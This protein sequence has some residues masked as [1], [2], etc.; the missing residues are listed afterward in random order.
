MT[1]CIEC[2]GNGYHQLLFSR[3]NCEVCGGSGEA[4]IGFDQQGCYPYDI[5]D[6]IK[7][8]QRRLFDALKIPKKYID[9]RKK[10]EKDVLEVKSR[11]KERLTKKFEKHLFEPMNCEFVASM[12]EAFN[13]VV[14]ELHEDF[15]IEHDA[16]VKVTSDYGSNKI[17]V[18]Y[19]LAKGG[20]ETTR[21][22]IE[23]NPV[24]EI[25]LSKDA[26]ELVSKVI[27]EFTADF[28]LEL[29]KDVPE[30][31]IEVK[32]WQDDQKF[33]DE[34]LGM[35][36]VT[37]NDIC[38]LIH[39]SFRS[40]DLHSTMLSYENTRI[41]KL[42]VDWLDKEAKNSCTEQESNQFVDPSNHWGLGE[43]MKETDLW[44]HCDF[45]PSFYNSSSIDDIDDIGCTYIQKIVDRFPLNGSSSPVI[46]HLPA[47]V[48]SDMPLTSVL[49]PD[50]ILCLTTDSGGTIDI[51]KDGNVEISEG[52]SLKEASVKFYEMVSNMFKS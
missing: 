29:S 49:I 5:N 27:P 43:Q 16:P 32:E 14:S 23:R 11:I 48:A 38:N 44:H 45:T 37:E 34:I 31:S 39:E 30:I 40:G 13:Q 52:L 28:K 9:N 50:S 18:D 22:E 33:I 41:C 19:S 47:N 51:K 15:P 7:Y 10:Y 3:V 1:E 20:L 25:E 4:L 35:A 8:V 42:Y 24:P 46:S 6:D 21:L 12:Q 17:I 36:L 2:K 26:E